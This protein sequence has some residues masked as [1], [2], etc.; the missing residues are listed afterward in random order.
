MSSN[1]SEQLEAI[2]SLDIIY[3]TDAETLGRENIYGEIKKALIAR[4][5]PEGEIAFIQ[6]Y[7][8]PKDKSRAFSDIN[9]GKIRVLLASTDT[10]GMGANFQE[11]L[12]AL[13]HL[14]PTFKSSEI[15]QRE[16]RILRQGNT[17]SEV[18]IIT[19]VT[20]GSFDAYMWGLIESKARFISQIMAGE[21]TARTAEDIDQ[22][23]MTAAQIKAIASGNP[24][25]LEKVAVEVELTRLERLYAAW[26][27]NRRRLER[28]AKDL[29]DYLRLNQAES[30]QC[31]A[32]RS[33]RDQT[34]DSDFLMQLR[35]DIRAGE[36]ELIEF[37]DRG[38]AGQQLRQ[39][40]HGLFLAAKFGSNGR[41]GRVLGVYRGFEIFGLVPY[42]DSEPRLSLRIS[43]Q[44]PS[45]EFTMR[46]SDV[47]VI[48]SMEHQ[49][50]DLD[51]KLGR[52]IANRKE[53]LKRRDYITGQLG[54]GWEHA[55]KYQALQVRLIKVNDDLFR[56]GIAVEKNLELSELTD[57]ALLPVEVSQIIAINPVKPPTIMESDAVVVE[58]P[59]SE[60][61]GALPVVAKNRRVGTKKKQIV[62]H[63][64]LSLWGD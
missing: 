35:P 27:D 23:V 60:E 20:E 36:N 16:G 12:Y 34:K 32:A 38:N 25:I 53:L 13:H 26:R 4:G 58:S 19:Y 42:K 40:T 57:D 14:T 5:I 54:N 48:L 15:E 6:S 18:N 1:N 33:L 30:E 52:L 21:V 59:Y 41:A 64:Q 43:H 28:Q 39:L 63:D 3:E 61:V 50:R 37:D 22:I 55:E 8:T 51:D 10:A 45:Y 24:A 11:R 44:T 29:P 31:E 49:L 7:K 17:F 47:G 62:R 9:A 46:E 56:A 2:E